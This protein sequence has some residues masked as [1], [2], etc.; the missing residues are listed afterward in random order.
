MKT[1]FVI[2][3]GR[4]GAAAAE[5]LYSMGHEV[6]IMDEDEELVRRLADQATH[7]AVGDAQ[8][9]AALRAAGAKECDCAIVAIGEDLAA[10]VIITMN[11]KDLG[12][13]Y[14]VCK[15]RDETYKRALERVGADR[16]VIPERE[17]ALRMVYSLGSSSFLDYIEF[18]SE[19]GIAEI[20]APKSWQGKTLR[21]IN[22]RGKHHVNV[23]SLKN[24]RDGT[25]L[26]SP[27]AD[28]VVQPHHVVMVMGR[29]EDLARMQKL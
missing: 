14:I 3:L 7:A 17:M 15:A 6:L 5:K 8:D 16:V 9:L 23:L 12:V 18:S 28:D 2:G 11:L 1:F 21:D 25:V 10:S 26:M 19:Y 29:N 13:P 27:G 20:A 22:A 24:E 4:F